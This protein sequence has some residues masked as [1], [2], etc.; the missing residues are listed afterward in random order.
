MGWL[1]KRNSDAFRALRVWILKLSVVVFSVVSV[2]RSPLGVI[3]FC[4]GKQS[5]TVKNDALV[6]PISSGAFFSIFFI[7]SRRWQVFQR[8]LCKGWPEGA[9]L[10][11]QMADWGIPRFRTWPQN[12]DHVSRLDHAENVLHQLST[13]IGEQRIFTLSRC[14]VLYPTS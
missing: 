1:S 2:H 12:L 9:I 8:S 4:F 3:E 11:G 5:T 10:V 6:H 13:L 7:F 14:P